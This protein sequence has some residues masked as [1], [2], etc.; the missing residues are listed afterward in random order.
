[1][2]NIPKVKQANNKSGNSLF[3]P[4]ETYNFFAIL[5]S[6]LTFLNLINELRKR[7]M[8]LSMKR[9]IIEF[10]RRVRLNE[11]QNFSILKI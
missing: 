1:M 5:R 10:Q 6:F 2:I 11:S 7:S 3:D 4:S 8:E 9:R